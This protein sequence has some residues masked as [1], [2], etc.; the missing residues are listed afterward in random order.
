MGRLGSLR[1]DMGAKISEFKRKEEVL[2]EEIH[3][4]KEN[5]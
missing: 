5:K 1:D 3:H 2:H 4:L